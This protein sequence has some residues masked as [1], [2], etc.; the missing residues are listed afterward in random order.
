MNSNEQSNH[1]Q[2]NKKGQ[3]EEQT[4]QRM[5][6]ELEELIQLLIELLLKMLRNEYQNRSMENATYQERDNEEW[7]LQN[8]FYSQFMADPKNSNDTFHNFEQKYER[9][10]SQQQE[11]E[12]QQQ[13]EPQ[14]EQSQEEE[15]D[16]YKTLGI[17]RNAEPRDIR[18]AFLKQ[19]L[20][21]HPDKVDN[22]NPAAVEEAT[23]KFKEINIAYGCLSEPSK[24]ENYDNANLNAGSNYSSPKPSPF[25]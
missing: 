16:Y 2:G 21:N 24:R 17:N 13:Q 12:D 7:E 1:E 19:S 11:N 15:K 8:E 23:Q 5:K 18:K 4:Q 20:A 9:E 22:S 3:E 6:K 10:Y 25:T 14:K